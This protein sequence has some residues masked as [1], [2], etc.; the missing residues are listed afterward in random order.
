MQK[1]KKL[2][3]ERHK[4]KLSKLFS[5]YVRRSNK[6][7]IRGLPSLIHKKMKKNYNLFASC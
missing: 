1:L 4:I 2:E 5:K 7:A 6:S 3:P